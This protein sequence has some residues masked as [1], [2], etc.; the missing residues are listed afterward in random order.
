M[1]QLGEQQPGRLA[2][3]AEQVLR[4]G[5]RVF[6]AIT[7]TKRGGGLTSGVP[8]APLSPGQANFGQTSGLPSVSKGFCSRCSQLLHAWEGTG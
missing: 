6:R 8:N 3:A 5:Q 2:Q 4:N 1:E 7:P